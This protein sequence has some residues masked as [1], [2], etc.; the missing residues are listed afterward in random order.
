[1]IKLFLVLSVI[2]VPVSSS[3]QELTCEQVRKIHA[4][5]TPAARQAVLAQMSPSQVAA[6]EQ[7]LG[8]RVGHARKR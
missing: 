4:K 2:L 1:M 7:C 6:V 8:A 5:L 3:T